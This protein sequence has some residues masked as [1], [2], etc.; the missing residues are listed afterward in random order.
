MRDY[1]KALTLACK[2]IAGMSGTCPYDQHEL[3]CAHWETDCER[4]CRPDIDM[5]E[6]WQRYFKERSA[7]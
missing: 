4:R 5:A 7:E 2:E 3:D 6:C 1:M